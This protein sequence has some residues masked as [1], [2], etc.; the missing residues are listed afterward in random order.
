MTNDIRLW[1][2]PGS[3]PNSSPTDWEDYAE[4][5]TE[6]VRQPGN[7]G[8]QE[9][10]YS[11][12][13]QDESTATDAGQMTLTLDNRDGRFSTDKIDGPYYGSLDINTPIRLGVGY[14]SD[15]FNRSVSNGWGTTSSSLGQSWTT[16]GTAS[17]YSVDGSKAQII[18][19]AANT[20]VICRASN[21]DARDVDITMT[22]T[23][24]AT[25][26]GASYGQGA[27]LR[28]TDTSNY[29]YSTLEF[30]TAGTTTVKIREVVAGV[31]TEIGAL[32]PIP[33]SSY[34]A[35][36]SWKLRTQADGDI[37]R[38]MAWPVS[39][40]Q[41]TAWQIT[42]TQDSLTGTQLGVYSV[43]FS[44]NSNS[45]VS[46]LLGLDEYVAVSLEWTG[47]VVSWPNDWDITGNNCWSAITASGVLRRL[48]QGANPVQ[49]PLRRQLAST[50]NCNGYWPMEEGGDALYF[51]GTV[52]GSNVASMSSVTPGADSTLPGGGLAP[53]L[54]SATGSI[55]ANVKG[56][57]DGTGFSAMFFV[58][59]PSLPG[60]KTRIARIR[61]NRGPVPIWD[62]SVDA[63]NTYIE[64]MNSEFTVT[65]SATNA[66]QED[67]TD[68]IAWQ[69]ETDNSLT[70]SKT[71]WSAIYHAVGSTDYWSQTGQVNG[72]TNSWVH[73]ITL[74]GP[75]ATAFAHIWLGRNTLPFVTDTFSLVSSGYAGETASD[76]FSRVCEE[77]GIQCTIAGDSV[78]SEAMGAQKEGTTMGI[79]QS[80]ADADFGVIAER[81]SGLDFI[82]RNTRWNLTQTAAISVSAGE[83]SS[84]PRPVRDDQKLRNKWTISRINGG[85]GTFQDD[86][87]IS[88][89]GTWEDSATINV[90]D[91]SVLENHA[92]WRVAIGTGSRM[93]WP[94][95]GMDFMR[96]PTLAVAWR[97]RL[98]GWRLG[99]ET[100]LTQ[101]SGNEPDVMVEGF[102]AT[103]SEHRWNVELNTVD[104]RIWTAAVADDTGIYGRADTD[105]CTTT[106]SINASDAGAILAVTTIS[107]YPTWDNTG[108]LWS[109]GVDLNVGGER[110]TVTAV[111]A[112]VGQAQTFTISARGV[113][114]YATSHA[115]GTSVSLWFPALVA[116]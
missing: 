24:A 94:N 83:I 109:G 79:L 95:I 68:W 64:G 61:T 10:K 30:N 36:Q 78:D 34:T 110:I 29:L 57:N 40:S 27:I 74:T 6:Y 58:K 7:D 28:Y 89:N 53:T 103:L 93:R 37:I 113:D 31:A 90:Y 80:C 13:R 45:G 2:Y 35:G 66:I 76:R 106:S 23:P 107:G 55:Y 77:A 115:S 46:S 21:S 104:A 4:E 9:I 63:T 32:N 56:A 48:R 44:G 51:L 25:A 72:T 111:S 62:L 47:Y 85:S 75:S 88:R 59:L 65:T 42:A 50:A 1:I 92:A 114:G 15:D 100:G 20:A 96:N 112:A 38:V 102:I 3:N 49:S 5:I 84:V 91:D 12:G 14:Y 98:Y 22:I 70:P 60:S 33:S 8:G 82:P 97:K 105:G 81:S 39:G 19:A 99:I 69:L 52:A 16:P 101:M 43:R 54:S 11:G 67:W 18:I 116:L 73:S 71:D 26:T 41:P 108:S 86:T 17:N 87:S